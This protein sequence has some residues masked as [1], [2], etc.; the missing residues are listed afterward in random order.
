MRDKDKSCYRVFL[1]LLK[2]A[3]RREALSSDELA[4]NLELSRGT[5]IHHIN[6]LMDAGLVVHHKSNYG[7]R[8]ERLGMLIAELERDLDS[9][10]KNLKEVAIDIDKWMGF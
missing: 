5:V 4:E 8:M 7:L 3:K 2:A 6:K 9:T 1:E 10:L